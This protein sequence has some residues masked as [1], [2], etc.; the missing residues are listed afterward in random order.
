MHKQYIKM[1]VCPSCHKELEWHIQEENEDRI[2][3]GKA[4]CLGCNS[5]Y[6]VKDEIAVFLTN[7]LS[8]NDLWDQGESALEKFF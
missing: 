1:L 4:C 3:N 7:E 5:E 8:R 2:I 6:E